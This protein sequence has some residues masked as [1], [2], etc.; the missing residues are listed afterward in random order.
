[1]TTFAISGLVVKFINIELTYTFACILPDL[2]WKF[3]YMP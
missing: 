2:G 1:M 3:H